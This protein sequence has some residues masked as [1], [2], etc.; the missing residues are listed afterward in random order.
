VAAGHVTNYA[1]NENG[2]VWDLQQ[3]KQ[4]LGVQRWTVSGPLGGGGN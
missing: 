2:D 4:H 3:L 1:Q